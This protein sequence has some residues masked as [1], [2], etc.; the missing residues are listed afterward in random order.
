MLLNR[1][2]PRNIV[3]TI[4][5]ADGFVCNFWR[6]I[7]SAPD[8]V[9]RWCDSP[10]SD[11]D[12]WARHRW[13]V[14]KAAELDLAATLESDAEF[15]DAKIAGWWVWGICCWIGSGWC[16]AKVRKR[17]R[18]HTAD[19]GKGVHKAAL[20]R[21][22]I[23][24]GDAGM[25]VHKAALHR[26]CIQ[27]GDAGKG[28]KY[29]ADMESVQQWLRVLSER[30]RPVRILC[31][32]WSRAVQSGV[33]RYGSVTGIYLDPPYAYD[34][35]REA[36]LYSTDSATVAH[37]VREWCIENGDN[38]K[39]RIALAGYDTEHGE[40]VDHGWTV[41]E[42]TP[43]GHG[44]A[45]GAEKNEQGKENVKRERLWLSPHCL[46]AKQETLF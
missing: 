6:S 21:K 23:H 27:T 45:S 24:T 34:A 38:P 16:S 26:N 8:D 18:I 46:H 14:D 44:Y 35:K 20:H 1:P 36:N 12:L 42:W 22:R 5:D 17:Q 40:L 25:G 37:D 39:F 11:L 41:S 30:L 7:Q 4:N 15:Y 10:P 3:E 33:L 9:A 29:S 19:T 32:D 31:G 43:H 28:A 13:L 2:E